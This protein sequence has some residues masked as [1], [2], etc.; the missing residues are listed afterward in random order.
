MGIK[1]GRQ[2]WLAENKQAETELRNR[3]RLCAREKK[4]A[5]C[6]NEKTIITLTIEQLFRLRMKVSHR[7]NQGGVKTR[8]RLAGET[9]MLVDMFSNR[10]CLTGGADRRSATRRHLLE[11]VGGLEC[12]H[13]K[14]F[15]ADC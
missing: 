3:S 4:K 11:G 9:P 14:A 12:S 7:G 1:Q 10:R 8:L 15:L 6:R 2:H 5:G 13:P